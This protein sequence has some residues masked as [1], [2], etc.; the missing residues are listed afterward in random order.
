MH[1]FAKRFGSASSGRQRMDLK[2]LRTFVTVAE[3]RTESKASQLLHISST[4]S[5]VVFS[6]ARV[7]PLQEV[8]W[9]ALYAFTL[10]L[11]VAIVFKTYG[12]TLALPTP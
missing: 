9:Y 11:I 4:S 7:N 1:K 6:P 3:A 5:L 8:A 10:W 12:K 2:H